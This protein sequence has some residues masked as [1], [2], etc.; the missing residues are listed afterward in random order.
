MVT[1]WIV[2]RRIAVELDTAVRGARV[3]DVGILDDGRFA[4]RLGGRGDRLLAVD[5]FGT[6]P[7]LTLEGGELPVATDPTYARSIGS[8]LRGMRIESV[9]SRHGDRVVALGFAVTSRFGV[10]TQATLVL[11]LIPR[12]GNIVLVRDGAVVAAAKQFDPAD[13]PARSV[14]LGASYEPPPL[15]EPRLD[16]ASFAAAAAGADRRSRIAALGGYLPQLPRLL[17]ESIVVESERAGAL[18]E[19]LMLAERGRRLLEEA[20]RR[21]GDGPVFVYRRDGT[22]AQAHVVPLAQFSDDVHATVPDLLPLLSESIADRRRAQGQDAVERRRSALKTRIERRLSALRRQLASLHER[23]NAAAD[24]DRLR[25]S[26]DALHTYGRLI[27]PRATTFRVPDRPDLTVELDP[28][29]TATENAA[30][31]FTR[32]RKAADALPHLEAR[33]RALEA[34]VASLEELA[35]SLEGAQAPV[36]AEIAADLDTIEGRRAPGLSKRSKPR[37]ILRLDRASGARIYVG[38]SPRE[39]VEVTFKI[40][41]GDDLWFHARA[42][43]GAHVVLAPPP[44]REPDRGDV[45]AAA[46]LAAAHSRARE[47]LRVDVE[48]TERKNVRKQRDAAPGLVWYTNARGIVGFPA[49]SGHR[50]ATGDG[51]AAV[52]GRDGL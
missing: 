34:T 7:L 50:D 20:E 44:G 25:M 2:I 24:R 48:Y 12:F 4:L 10:G 40:A 19:P 52:L 16:A 23:F 1:D 46:D 47:A 39:N 38:R 42:I 32:Y 35:W 5:P 41:R 15:Q 30:R 6:P 3:T 27:P 28:E 51:T 31:Y 29:L 8:T 11:E 37:P 17:A 36:L 14:V 26:G 45:Q 18:I 33:R 9:R 43:P 21:S 22:I 49:A 13:N